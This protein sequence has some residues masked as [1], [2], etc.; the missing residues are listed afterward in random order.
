M[1][2]PSKVKPRQAPQKTLT[3]ADIVH[4]VYHEHNFASRN[5]AAAITDLVLDTICDAIESDGLVKLSGFGTFRVLNKG[6]R[7]GRDLAKGVPVPIEPRKSVVFRASPR[8]K[9]KINGVDTGA[10]NHEER[11]LDEPEEPARRE[12]NVRDKPAR[13]RIAELSNG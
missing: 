5:E 4:V 8:M 1:E 11:L 10:D 3:K 2:R 6:L 12:D 13:N 9:D 7:V